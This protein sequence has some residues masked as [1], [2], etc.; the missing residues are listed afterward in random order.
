MCCRPRVRTSENCNILYGLTAVIRMWDCLVQWKMSWWA[1]WRAS[2]CAELTSTCIWVMIHS[3]RRLKRDLEERWSLIFQFHRIK[4]VRVGLIN[5]GCF[6]FAATMEV[7][8]IH[9]LLNVCVCYWKCMWYVTAFTYTC[10]LLYVWCLKST[11][12]W[13][14]TYLINIQ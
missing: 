14:S 2:C 11:Y 8:Y 12:L 9:I 7:L 10:Y 6:R 3:T 4:G 5:K 13:S 1:R